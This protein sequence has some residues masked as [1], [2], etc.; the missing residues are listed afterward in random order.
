M[1]FKPCLLA[2]SALFCL[3]VFAPVSAQTVYKCGPA[4][5]VTY[6]EKPCSNRIVNTGEAPIAVRPNPREVDVHRIEQNRLLARTLRP[7]PGE[8]TEQFETRRRRT[9]L[10]ETDRAECARLDT[11]MPVEQARMNSPDQEEVSSAQAA[12]RESRRRFSRLRC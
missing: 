4:R 8:S 3:S 6:T 11:R 2:L 10:L 5:S 12:L 7:R 1:P 9:R